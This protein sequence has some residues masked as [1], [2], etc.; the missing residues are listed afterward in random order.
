MKK[1]TIKERVE[2]IE[3]LSKE[4]EKQRSFVD[5]MFRRLK[6]VIKY[7]DKVI[8]FGSMRQVGEYHWRY[9]TLDPK[10]TAKV[11]HVIEDDLIEKEKELAKLLGMEETK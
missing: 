9:L 7:K 11:V 6:G 8:N 10:L 1:E 5:H 3:K 2:K 4:I